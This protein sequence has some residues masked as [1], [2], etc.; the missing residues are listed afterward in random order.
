M[1]FSEKNFYFFDQISLFVLFNTFLWV[2]NAF[3]IFNIYFRSLK[4]EL[5]GYS[6]RV[7]LIS[8]E[9]S[10]NSIILGWKKILKRH[11]Q[12]KPPELESGGSADRTGTN[13][14]GFLIQK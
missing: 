10:R 6:T 11:C 7:S 8:A 2:E 1:Y 9:K 3:F 13:F 4:F 5:K 14:F 12:P